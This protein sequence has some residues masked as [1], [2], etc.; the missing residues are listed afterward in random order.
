MVA[1]VASI[2]AGFLGAALARARHPVDQPDRRHRGARRR[3][4]PPAPAARPDPIG[5]AALAETLGL[6][7]HRPHEA[8][9]DALTTA[10][11]FLALAAHLDRSRLRPSEHGKAQPR[12]A[13][14]DA[15][16]PIAASARKATGSAGA[17]DADSPWCPREGV[18]PA[19]AAERDGA[20]GLPRAGA[21][22][23]PGPSTRSVRPWRPRDGGRAAGPSPRRWCRAGGRL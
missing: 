14:A 3:A 13:Q 21:A 10:Q 22:D 5:L 11:V 1:H 17:I 4:L 23:I 8:D 6:P 7:V 20:S 18:A 19:D 12:D 15:A 2:E 9:G 16:S